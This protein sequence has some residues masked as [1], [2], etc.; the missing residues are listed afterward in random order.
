MLNRI[1]R[2]VARLLSRAGVVDKYSGADL[3]S[4]GPIHVCMCGSTL[5]KVGCMFEDGDISMWFV[6]GEC[7]L[8]GALVK[9]PTPVDEMM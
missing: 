2:T 4:L 1:N 9:V 7:A 3:R 8:C 5:F 6:D